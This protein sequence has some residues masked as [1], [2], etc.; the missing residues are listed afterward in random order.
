MDNLE[1]IDKFLETHNVI[2]LSQDETK[3]EDTTKNGNE[4]VIKC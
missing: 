2:R 1:E 4:P 3:Y